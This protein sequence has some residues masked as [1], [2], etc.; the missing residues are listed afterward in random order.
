MFFSSVKDINRLISKEMS[1]IYLNV[2]IK[3]NWRSRNFDFLSLKN[4]SP[5]EL[6]LAKEKR[7]YIVLPIIKH[8][9]IQFFACF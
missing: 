1:N 8:Y 6:E 9:F 3:K 2:T 5:G 7:I 4:L